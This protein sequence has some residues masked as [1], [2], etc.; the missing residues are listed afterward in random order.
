[1]RSL[2]LIALLTSLTAAAQV[3]PTTQ[4]PSAPP[5]PPG[6]D[7]ATPD[8]QWVYTQQ[9]GWLWLPYDASYAQTTATTSLAYAYGPALGWSWI[10]APWVIGLGPRPWF[11]TRIARA[12]YAWWRPVIHPA[13]VMTGP[14]HLGPG[15]AHHA[16]GRR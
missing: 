13:R 10:N 2:I 15:F 16:R 11:G 7:V 5:P 1:M 4:M 14:R 3:A 6:V 9:Y 12:H 8:G